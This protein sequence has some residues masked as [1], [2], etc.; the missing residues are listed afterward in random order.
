MAADVGKPVTQ[1]E[2]EVRRTADLLRD[3]AVLRAP[4]TSGAGPR[5]R[6]RIR[7]VPVGV[8]AAITPWNNPRGDP[9]GQDRAR[10][11]RSGNAVVWKPAPAATAHRRCARCELARDAGLPDGRRS[12]WWP[13]ITAAAAP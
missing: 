10:R 7:R 5:L 1:G 3:A 12:A 13:A 11:S 2:A 4:A 8:V 6:L 9:V